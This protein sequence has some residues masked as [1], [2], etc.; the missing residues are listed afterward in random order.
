ME[1]SKEIFDIIQ[2]EILHE[3]EEVRES[4]MNHFSRQ[5]DKFIH[6]MANAI[7]D[8]KSFDDTIMGE[9]DKAA[10]SAILYSAI[11]LNIASMKSFISGNIIAA[12]NLQRQVL[13]SIAMA[14]LCSGKSLNILKMFMEQQYSPNK[15]IRDVIKHSAKLNLNRDALEVLKKSYEF[16]HNYSHLTYMTISSFV[17]FS[18]QGLYVGSSFDEEKISEYQKE[19]NSRISLAGIFSNVIDGVKINISKWK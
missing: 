7:R 6:E 3:N 12:G 18:D 11:T 2:N 16:Y 17:S 4:F 19:I 8:W 13:E 1:A 5:I 15:A 14:F 10:V 9:K